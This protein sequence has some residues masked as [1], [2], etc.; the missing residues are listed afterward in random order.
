MVLI[1]SSKGQGTGFFLRDPSDSSRWYV[2]TNAHVVE[3]DQFVE[4]AWFAGLG[5]VRATVLGIDERA[6][7]ALLN[8]GPDDFDWSGTSWDS[9]VSY[10][11]RLGKGLTVSTDIRRGVEVMAVGYPMG[12]GGCR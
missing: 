10:I 9:G 4:V 1:H 2:V 11:S 5:N 12:G 8:I 6:D 3:R 7:V